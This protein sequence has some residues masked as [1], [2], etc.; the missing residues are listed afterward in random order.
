M[1]NSDE[2][3][4]SP[5]RDKLSRLTQHPKANFTLYFNRHTGAS[6]WILN[7]PDI[8]ALTTSSGMISGMRI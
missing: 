6:S 8:F 2:Y 1:A 3:L 4:N 5:G 7:Y